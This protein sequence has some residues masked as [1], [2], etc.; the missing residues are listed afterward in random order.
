MAR[1]AWL[2][3]RDGDPCLA[4]DF[5]SRVAVVA[6]LVVVAGVAS[7]ANAIVASALAFSRVVALSVVALSTTAFSAAASS[8]VFLVA[9]TI[10]AFP[11]NVVGPSPLNLPDLVT[12]AAAALESD[13]CAV[14]SFGACYPDSGA[15]QLWIHR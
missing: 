4:P 11:T 14:S 5:G 10:V 3:P 1:Y 9:S 7:L 13:S 6:S 8:M 15:H 2:L 12:V